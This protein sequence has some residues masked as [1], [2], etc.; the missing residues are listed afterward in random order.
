MRTAAV[1]V[2]AATAH[3]AR[4]HVESHFDKYKAGGEKRKKNR[5]TT[6]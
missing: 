5:P 2:N 4:F 6:T 1:G 3:I